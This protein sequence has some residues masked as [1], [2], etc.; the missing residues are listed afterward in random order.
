MKKT[1]T[2][3]NIGTKI[4]YAKGAQKEA[5]LTWIDKHG[6]AVFEAKAL[7]SFSKEIL[8]A[9]LKRDSLQIKEADLFAGILRWGKAK[10][11]SDSPEALQGTLKGL[12][13]LVRFPIMSTQEIATKVVPTGL[14]TSAQVLSLFTYVSTSEKKEKSGEKLALPSDLKM[15]S[16]VKRKSGE[17]K[18]LSFEYS[19]QYMTAGSQNIEHLNDWNDRTLQRGICATSPGWINIE[20]QDKITIHE[21]ELGGWNGNSSIWSCSNG[22]G[23]TIST[24]NDKS[25][26]QQVGTIPYGF[27]A[28][29]QRVALTKTEAKFVRFQSTGY[30][31]IGYFKILPSE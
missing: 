15:F 22:G 6:K 11:K 5:C 19:G 8:Q 16:N 26:W 2:E 7:L 23:S 29:I 12:V 10:S 17:T 25:S 28:T 1:L 27:G 20:L 4:G 3:E 13:E 18:Y 21:I 24:S 9:V 31:G 30:L 14:L